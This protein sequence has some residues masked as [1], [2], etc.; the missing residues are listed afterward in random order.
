V[1]SHADKKIPSFPTRRNLVKK[2][3]GSGAEPEAK[4]VRDDSNFA[5]ICN[6][7]QIISN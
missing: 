4:P 3:Q 6:Y 5:L 2:S 1:Q 7:L